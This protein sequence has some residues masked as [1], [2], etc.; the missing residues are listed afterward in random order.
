MIYNAD[1]F[2]VFPLIEN[3][4]ID[5]VV[6]DL[7]YGQTDCKW[8]TKIDLEKLWIE[9]KRISKDN[10]Q[11]IFFTTTKF[12]NNLINSNPQWFRYDL[13]WEKNNSSAGFLNSK[14][15]PLRNYE[16]LYVFSNPTKK[17]KI[18]NPQMTKGEPYIHNNI[19]IIQNIV[20]N[21][22]ALSTNSNKS[23]DRYPKSV[24][25]FNVIKK[26]KIHSTQKP[27]ELL[28]WIIKTYS[29]ENDLI[30]DCCMGSG[31]T[32]IACKNT[33][34]NYIGIEMDKEIFEKAKDRIL[35]YK[36]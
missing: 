2:D 10:T 23:G 16:M 33:N 3:N 29:N 30:L 21:T 20:Y 4:I 24:L 36:L 28:E 1:C 34:R 7:P 22:T 26:N 6:L 31:S 32:I 25:K 18:Y 13:V 5:L 35:S 15:M 12:G 8:D 11:Y 14:K 19:K 27:V 9:L 17:G